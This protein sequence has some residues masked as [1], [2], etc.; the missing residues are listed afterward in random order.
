MISSEFDP[1]KGESTPADALLISRD[2]FFTSKITGTAARLGFRVKAVGNAREALADAPAGTYRCIFLDLA[3]P[4]LRVSDVMAAMP[5]K[6]RP[7]IV[8]FGAHVHTERLNE[9]REAGC[10][11]VLVRGEFSSKLPELLTRL[12]SCG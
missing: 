8:A 2:V 7:K 12:L 1:A 3:N 10:D 5:A 6:A 11:L 4:D 9:A